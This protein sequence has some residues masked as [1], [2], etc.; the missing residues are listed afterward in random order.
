[1]SKK[2]IQGMKFE[3]A[4]AELDEL[5]TRLE[6]G[7]VSLEESVQIYERGHKLKAYCTDLLKSAEQRVEKIA[8]RANGKPLESDPGDGIPF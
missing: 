8:I 7:D 4:M 5:V 6:S 1:M 3:E 2:P